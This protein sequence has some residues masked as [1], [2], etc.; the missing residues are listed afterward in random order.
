MRR[1]MLAGAALVALGLAACGGPGGPKCGTAVCPTG[2]VCCN[3]V[4]SI[5]TL[6]GE[7]CIQ[8]LPETNDPAPQ[9][10]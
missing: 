5:C 7:V 3:P 9:A 8:A 2:M 1:W 10:E 4:A 6:P